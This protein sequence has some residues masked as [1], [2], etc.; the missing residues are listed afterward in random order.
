MIQTTLCY[1]EKDGQYLMLHRTKKKN[2]VNH[3]K[4]IGI[5]GKFETDESP[6]ECVIR[7]MYEETGLAP[8]LL[9]Y[10]GVITFVCEGAPSEMMH[11]FLCRETTGN[12]IEKCDEGELQWIK[13]EDLLN[14][15][16]W[17]GDKIFLKLLDEKC[18]FFSLKL[19][20][21]NDRLIYQK[22]HFADGSNGL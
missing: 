14:L 22:L 3:D 19:I 9:E 13:K 10:R 18:P 11:L 21:K 6:Y 1:I 20:Y 12:I 8:L 15:T 17:E 4:W 7:E 5:G 16:L 2:D